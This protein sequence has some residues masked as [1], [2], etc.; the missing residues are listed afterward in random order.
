MHVKALFFLFFLLFLQMITKTLALKVS[1]ST[2]PLTALV[3][4]RKR[5]NKCAK[6]KMRIHETVNKLG[7]NENA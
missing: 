1:S 5:R 4:L 2:R 6:N 7:H 3:R